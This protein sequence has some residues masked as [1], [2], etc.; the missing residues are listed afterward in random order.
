MN[1]KNNPKKEFEKKSGIREDAT[2]KKE[3]K[4]ELSEQEAKKQIE[5][6]AQLDPSETPTFK[7]QKIQKE[8][9]QDMGKI[10]QDHLQ[11]E[12]NHIS[13]KGY[14]NTQQDYDRIQKNS[15]YKKQKII[16]RSVEDAK[17]YYRDNGSL[18]QSFDEKSKDKNMDK[19]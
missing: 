9:D 18:T 13:Y 12:M 16:N 15:T 7:L 19:E 2:T 5:L 11:Q 1:K 10:K 6:Y 3:V 8:L 17:E 14:Q 4:K